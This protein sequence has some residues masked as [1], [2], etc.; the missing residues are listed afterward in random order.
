[1]KATLL[2]FSYLFLYVNGQVACVFI[3]AL[4][5]LSAFEGQKGPSIPLE[6]VAD[7]FEPLCGCR[8][9]KPGPLQE[10]L[11]LLTMAPAL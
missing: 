9:L 5:S 10:Q 4:Y 8:K 7:R 3:Y 11:M 6:L 2:L 1:M